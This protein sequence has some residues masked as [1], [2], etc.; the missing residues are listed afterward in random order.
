VYTGSTII[1]SGN[2][3]ANSGT[4]S[5][6]KTTGAMV[7]SGGLGVTG[8]QYVNAVYTTTGI[9]WEANGTNYVTG[10]GAGAVGT[11]G[12][13]QFNNA[14]VMG[15][16]SLRYYNSNAAVAA[17]GGLASTSTTTGSFQVLGGAGITGALYNALIH[18]SGG[19]IV[20]AATTESTSTTT[21][22]FVTLGGVG[23]A[24]RLNVGGN[25]VATATTE[26][27][28]TTT[29]SIVTLGGAGIANRLNVGGNIVAAATTESTSTTTGSFVA[30]GGVG[31]ANRLNVGGNIVA[32]A[33]TASTNTTTGSF[34]ALGGVGIAGAVYAGSI[35]NT[36]VGSTTTS[37]GAFTT[38]SASTALYVSASTAST[39][40]NTGAIVTPGGLG[41]GGT[42]YAGGIASISGN[43]TAGAVGTTNQH[44]LLSS[45]VSVPNA[46]VLLAGAHT[47][48]SGSGGNYLAF[49]QNTG[50]FGQ[51]IQSAF[52]NPTTATYPIILNP[53]GGNVVVGAS[54]VSTNT[55][56]GALVVKGG[57][58]I[59]GALYAG[60][61]F[62]NGVRVVS[63]ST[64]AG[65]LSISATAINLPTHG[66]GAT[67]QGST[68]AIPV[69]TTDAY[70]RVT[71][72]TTAAVAT[73]HTITGTTGSQTISNG[74]T[75]TFT[76]PNGVTA[77][78]TTGPSVAIST[79]QD[80][81]TTAAPTFAGM[82]VTAAIVPSGNLT[83]D[84]GT[85]TAW[86]NNL[87][88]RAIQTQYGDVAEK[89]LA[90]AEYPVGTVV[91]VGGDA[92]VT[93]CGDHAQQRAIGVVSENPAL[94]MNA[95]LEGGTFI[96]LKGRVP[97][98][99]HGAVKKG[100]AL[101]A[102]VRPDNPAGT[103]RGSN[104]TAGNDRHREFAIA[105]ETN[106]DSGVKIVEAIIL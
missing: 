16:S 98:L 74:G 81:R 1:A 100:E 14:G 71:A 23:I 90:D 62:D 11:T 93:A 85:T 39:T 97:V 35:Q 60:S 34:V 36:P 43:I 52:T 49:G 103:A 55:T 28:G 6:T 17:I 24:N 91:V 48:L 18:V 20:A 78:A 25:V 104:A 26:S 21:G 19:N 92:E 51:W 12:D 94:K 76:S 79:P 42:I 27:T 53:L 68:T 80:V 106:L 31:I 66:P 3:V 96:A 59:A 47:A 86:F 77:V 67:T 57:T 75:L 32:A 13:L 69:I 4:A 88:G 41:I 70:G 73:S 10:I 63:T 87:Y 45:T 99:V 38:L 84:I 29:G 33:T 56:T 64:G 102:G 105:L 22:S 37:T 5:T 46:T 89:Y 30:L 9:F 54:T 65:N 72:L 8:S 101:V 58:G 40:S 15:A 44:Q 2:V 82:T 95:M 61:V 50:N 83:V 7:V